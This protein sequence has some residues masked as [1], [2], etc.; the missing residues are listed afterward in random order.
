MKKW[1]KAKWE[2]IHEHQIVK[3]Y[4]EDTLP[5]KIKGIYED[6]LIAKYI[7]S[8][9]GLIF[10]KKG[11]GRPFNELYIEKEIKWEQIKIFE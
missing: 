8:N 9:S 10:K 11:F 2:E 1:V 5:L 6:H 7:G 3:Q 4:P